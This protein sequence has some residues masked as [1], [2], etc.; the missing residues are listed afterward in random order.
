MLRRA[1]LG[2]TLLALFGC[3]RHDSSPS[4]A[5]TPRHLSNASL[6][7][8]REA[9]L[10]LAEDTILDRPTLPADASERAAWASPTFDPGPLPRWL[11]HAPVPGETIEQLALRYGVQPQS[12]REW[13]HLARDEQPS[14]ERKRPR[15]L[16]IYAQ[17]YAPP[18]E[19]LEH[20][21]AP[22][23]T[24]LSVARA[25]GVDSA[26]LRSWNVADAGRELEPGERLSVWI[27]PIV[28]HSIVWDSMDPWSSLGAEARERIDAV[29]AGAHGVGTPQDGVL[30]AGV[31]IPEGPGYELRFPNS[32]WGTTFAVRH[33][34]AALDRFSSSSDYPLPIKVGTMSRQRGGPVGGHESHQTGRDL[35]VRL[36]LR[37]TVPQGLP[38]TARRTD[39]KATWELIRA[40]A[41]SDAVQVIF[42][43]Y[44]MQKRVHKAALAA[45][46]SEAELAKLLQWPRGSASNEALVRHEPGHEH[47][48]HVRYSCGPAEPEC[49]D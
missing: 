16:R 21:V 5:T 49:I 45:G 3:E 11:R 40:F 47:H 31:A 9:E 29:R 38:P 2:M 6:E 42:L 10:T 24:W 8:E 26:E 15:A 19:L 18:R 4:A 14:F 37:P 28:Y 43:D 13:N 20:S 34:L 35:D 17:R 25:Y 41:Q 27:D 33:T 30:V 44:A 39:W 48:I 32:A 46:A 22:G 23:E 7:R 1:V 36:P 12:I